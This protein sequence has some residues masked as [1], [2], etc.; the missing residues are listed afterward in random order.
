MPRY[1][2]TFARPWW[3]TECSCFEV[4][5]TTPELALEQLQYLIIERKVCWKEDGAYGKVGE[6]LDLKAYAGA[7]PT[8]AFQPAG[9]NFY[10]A[11]PRDCAL[12]LDE[13]QTVY[14]TRAKF[15]DELLTYSPLDPKVVQIDVFKTRL[16]EILARFEAAEGFAKRKAAFAALPLN[17]HYDDLNTGEA[18]NAWIHFALSYAIEIIHVLI[19]FKE[20]KHRLFNNLLDDLCPDVC[21][22]LESYGD[23]QCL[24]ARDAAL[25]ITDQVMAAVP[26]ILAT[27]ATPEAKAVA[28]VNNFAR[29]LEE[30]E[31][32]AAKITAFVEKLYKDHCLGPDAYLQPTAIKADLKTALQRFFTTE[33]FAEHKRLLNTARE[34]KNE[35]HVHRLLS[36]DTPEG[37]LADVCREWFD[38]MN[39]LAGELMGALVVIDS[40]YLERGGTYDNLCADLQQ[41]VH[42]FCISLM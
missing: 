42:E 28:I 22:A 39:E 18:N 32:T 8:R 21:S 30:E 5:A 25:K 41:P 11:G 23:E 35:E 7:A 12:Y 3:T 31:S 2:L 6:P 20:S 19:P 36:L 10:T 34:A 33:V 40:E 14:D 4:F 17:R 16:D 38:S 26:A 13:Q 1:Q 24:L 15:I 29:A 37:D 9:S 27:D